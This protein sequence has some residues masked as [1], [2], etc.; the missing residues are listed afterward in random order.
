[1]N[2]RKYGKSFTALQSENIFL[3]WL[4]ASLTVLVIVMLFALLHKR[5]I[6]TIQPFTLARDAQVTEGE[7]SR[8]Y[9]EA[10]GLALAE[11][12]GN[13]HPGNAGFIGEHLKPLLSPQIYH[14]TIDA[15]ESDA[16]SLREDRISLRFEP[17]RVIYEKST[18][19]IFVFGHSYVRA[20][21]GADAEKK[22]AR[23]YE[24]RMRI[25]NYLPEVLAINTYEGVPKTRDEVERQEKRQTSAQAR[26]RKK[27][28]QLAPSEKEKAERA[29]SAADEEI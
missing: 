22:S 27:E 26:E 15:I 7:A 1:M 8:T 6:V 13:V 28:R 19:K 29:A 24:F 9:M 25:A 2:F 12:I 21:T 17:L 5:T 16:Q 11:V 14:Q 20:G 3:R 10:W 4:A 23:T 18:G